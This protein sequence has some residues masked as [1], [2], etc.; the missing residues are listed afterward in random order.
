MSAFAASAAS[1]NALAVSGSVS[2]NS[3]NI[4]TMSS[5][6]GRSPAF[7]ESQ[8]EVGPSSPPITPILA[9]SGDSARGFIAAGAPRVARRAMPPGSSYHSS[10]PRVARSAVASPRMGPLSHERRFWTA[11][12]R[13]GMRMGARVQETPT[14]AVVASPSTN[15]ACASESSK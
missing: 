11:P 6:G 12:S 2:K 5:F 7:D 8:T 15:D 14:K 1:K 3:R 4:S 9:D 13:P 10:E